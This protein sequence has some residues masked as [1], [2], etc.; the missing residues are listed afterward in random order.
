[1]AGARWPAWGLSQWL[2]PR[3]LKT[4]LVGAKYGLASD[5]L[6]SLGVFLGVIAIATGHSDG[7]EW[8]EFP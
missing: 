8:L 3:L 7:L 4:E 6:W 1:M 2:I 5:A